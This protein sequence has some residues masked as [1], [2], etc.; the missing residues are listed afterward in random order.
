MRVHQCVNIVICTTNNKRSSD[1]AQQP[2]NVIAQASDALILTILTHSCS[3]RHLT[4]SR[5][6]VT[7]AWAWA[8]PKLLCFG[9]PDLEGFN[10]TPL[11]STPSSNRQPQPLLERIESTEDQTAPGYTPKGIKAK[12]IKAKGIKAFC[13]PKG[14]KGPK[15]LKVIPK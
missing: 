14:I 10:L 2:F 11:E 4:F 8:T 6:P 3:T 5:S 9:Q 15:V 7:H 13:K 12:G 1:A